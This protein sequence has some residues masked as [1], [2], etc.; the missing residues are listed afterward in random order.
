MKKIIVLLAVVV[1]MWAFA[2]PEVEDF[3]VRVDKNMLDFVGKLPQEKVYLHT[4]RDHYQVGDKVWLRAYLANA[5][6]HQE[7]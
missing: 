4:D 5:I 1:G 3:R 7:S 2:S 6:T